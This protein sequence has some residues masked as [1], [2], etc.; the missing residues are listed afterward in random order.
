MI[1]KIVLLDLRKY[2]YVIGIT[3]IIE[4]KPIQY[5]RYVMYLVVVFVI[6][7]NRVKVSRSRR[8]N[9]SENDAELRVIEFFDL[10]RFNIEQFDYN[11]VT[12]IKNQLNNTFLF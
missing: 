11:Y 3:V 9:T 5:Y 6:K 12:F 1:Q 10:F 2:F 7:Y 8:N 4:F